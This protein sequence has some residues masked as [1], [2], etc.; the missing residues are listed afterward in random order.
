MTGID[1]KLLSGISSKNKIIMASVTARLSILI[2]ELA[3][4]CAPVVIISTP[5]LSIN[6]P[7]KASKKS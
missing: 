1:Q 3:V 2:P 4:E 6:T 7:S 5:Y